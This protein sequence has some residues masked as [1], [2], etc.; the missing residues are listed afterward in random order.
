[1]LNAIPNGSAETLAR[2]YIHIQGQLFY[3]FSFVTICNIYA[4]L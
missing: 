2:G 4:S 3:N 1:M